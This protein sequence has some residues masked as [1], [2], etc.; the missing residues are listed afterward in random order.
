MK[1]VSLIPLALGKL[2]LAG[3]MA[4][5]A[6]KLS[7]LL[8]SILGL[9]K[10]FAGSDG[11]LSQ[12]VHHYDDGHYGYYGGGGQHAHRRVTY[13]VRGRGLD[14]WTP[15]IGYDSRGSLTANIVGTLDE[16]RTD[17][18]RH[19]VQPI[20][21]KN[22]ANVSGRSEDRT[23]NDDELHENRKISQ[24]ESS[25][26]NVE[27]VRRNTSYDERKAATLT[28]DRRQ[29]RHMENGLHETDPNASSYG[30]SV[31]VTGHNTLHIRGSGQTDG[32]GVASATGTRQDE[33][34]EDES[35][36]E[37]KHDQGKGIANETIRPV[38]RHYRG[39]VEG[40]NHDRAYREGHRR[41]DDVE[42]Q[43]VDAWVIRRKMNRA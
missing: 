5:V 8:V 7:L 18:Q 36:L 10:L 27:S 25:D 26:V 38:R 41:L 29:L 15:S 30:G 17:S 33:Q 35:G 19:L 42:G 14:D 6:S 39:V 37:S 2:A 23:K 31:T 43:R 11:G 21:N 1:F 34:I 22:R 32:V 24:Q 3:T 12:Q 40:Q 9:K 13:F 28:D 4:L 16:V 20:G